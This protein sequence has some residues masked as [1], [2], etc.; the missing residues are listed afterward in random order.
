MCKPQNLTWALPCPQEPIPR[1]NLSHQYKS[2]IAPYFFKSHIYVVI[3]HAV[4][5]NEFKTF[6]EKSSLTFQINHV[7]PECQ[8]RCMQ[9]SE[10][11]NEVKLH[12]FKNKWK[13]TNTINIP[14]HH[15]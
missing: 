11:R 13:G 9:A 15:K 1:P 10:L 6:E 5:F 8:T 3:L 12:N 2:Y 7:L 14:S 4:R